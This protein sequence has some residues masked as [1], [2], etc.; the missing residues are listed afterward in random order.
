VKLAILSDIHGNLEALEAVLADVDANG[1]GAIACLGDFVGY[2]ASPNECLDRLRP[3]LEA[4]VVGNHDAAA[5]GRVRLGGF[6]ADAA[7]TARWTVEQLTPDHRAWLA[8]LPYSIQWR[9]HR[10]VH[11][12]PSEPEEWHYVLSAADAEI[13]MLAYRERMGF[14]GRSHVPGVFGTDGTRMSYARGQTVRL[15]KGHRYLVNVGSVGQPRDGDARAAWMCFDEDRDALAHRRVEYDIERAASRIRD[16]G[17]PQFL[18]ERL[19]WGE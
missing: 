4:A 19:R 10:L 13:E 5:L 3:R 14:I 8:N 12:T 1:A 16:A 18:A 9:G 2:G 11:A 7:T 17:L 15:E 6:H